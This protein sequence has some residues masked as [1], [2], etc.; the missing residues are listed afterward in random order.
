MNNEVSRFQA[1]QSRNQANVDNFSLA[2]NGQV[3][4]NDPTHPTVDQGTHA[5]KWNCGVRGIQ[6]SD[7]APYPG[8]VRIR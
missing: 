8:C 4:T 1:G 7:I 5:G 6:D 3:T 2:L